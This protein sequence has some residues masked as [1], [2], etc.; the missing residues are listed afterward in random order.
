MAA[1]KKVDPILSA[2]TIGDFKKRFYNLVVKEGHAAAATGDALLPPLL[3]L[4]YTIFVAVTTH[5][6]AGVGMGAAFVPYTDADVVNWSTAGNIASNPELI[7]R[8]ED[9][10]TTL[11]Q[12]RLRM[13]NTT[14]ADKL[15]YENTKKNMIQDANATLVH[16]LIKLTRGQEGYK[17]LENHSAYTAH[18]DAYD[19]ISKAQMLQF[20]KH[21]FQSLFIVFA[22]MFARRL[23]S[24]AVTHTSLNTPPNVEVQTL[25]DYYKIIR[26]AGEAVL[27]K[28]ILTPEALV[29]HLQAES[30]ITHINMTAENK[31]LKKEY[32]GIYKVT[33]AAVATDRAND[34]RL[35]DMAR[36]LAHKKNLDTALL[37][38]N[39]QEIP[40]PLSA[41]GALRT[42]VT[43]PAAAHITRS[44]RFGK[45]AA[46]GPVIVCFHCNKSGHIAPL[47]PTKKTPASLRIAEG[48]RAAYVLARD[49]RRSVRADE[50]REILE[51]SALLSMADSVPAIQYDTDTDNEQDD[52]DDEI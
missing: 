28:K 39:F 18:Q 10:N 50:N 14:A 20:Y 11:V 23:T 7:E 49:A 38:A 15:I 33:R 52:E 40:P 30:L 43:A 1:A 17:N 5:N 46:T 45:G 25:D 44:S 21:S 2:P 3:R 13:P 9:V 19:V 24:S 34:V 37:A 42:M 22:E 51:E 12:M 31:N 41:A 32:T 6:A 29:D 47:C 8:I 16:A 26:D 48:R 36:L 4:H 27:K 35:F